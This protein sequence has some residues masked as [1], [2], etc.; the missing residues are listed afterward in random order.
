MALVT[1][2]HHQ[3]ID[4][5]SAT[6]KT[7]T[8]TPKVVQRAPGSDASP[9]Q[10]LSYPY[11]DTD[12]NDL[13]H[14]EQNPDDD[15]IRALQELQQSTG[16]EVLQFAEDDLQQQMEEVFADA[17]DMER[18]AMRS[19]PHQLPQAAVQAYYSSSSTS[20]SKHLS[21]QQGSENSRSSSNKSK[22]LQYATQRVTRDQE[23][24]LAQTIQTGA[25]L[26]A[27]KVEAESQQGRTL[28]KTE[29]AAL[30]DLTP[31]ELRR[32]IS[33]YRQAKQIL[34]AANM[35]LVHAV[36]N[37]QW[38]AYYRRSGVSKEELIQE[39]S[40][41]LLRAAELF[42]PNKG[43]RF[44]TY[45]VVWIKGVLQ[46]THVPELVRLPQR[47]KT[48]WHKIMKAQTDLQNANGGHPP[49]L[50]EVADATGLPIRDVY[51]THRHMGATQSV[52]SLDTTQS[53]QSRSGTETSTQ[54]DVLHNRI[55]DET[56]NELVT[57]TQLQADLIAALARN[58]DAREARLVRLRYGL[59]DGVARSLAECADAMGLSQTRVQQLNQKCLKKLRAADEAAS[60][61]EYLLTIA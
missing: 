57:R 4:A 45:A 27:L 52:W 7:R 40:L 33:H 3:T 26:Q 16:P 49:S 12:D 23:V 35:G 28:S 30:A 8:A 6:T 24:L 37:Q 19:I 17:T 31:K 21:S 2:G 10:P 9:R 42:D 15:L 51:E 29:W 36:V 44:S 11:Q 18:L 46:N 47:E 1:V 34:V 32:K 55:K 48:K 39:G 50:E 43:L 5:F 13:L 41:G 38:S 60:L 54:T 25:R 53:R 22:D 61:Q 20:N 56:E 59:A 14:N 58:L